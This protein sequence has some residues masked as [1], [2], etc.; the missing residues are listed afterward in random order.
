MCVY[1]Y[2]HTHTHT[3]GIDALLKPHCCAGWWLGLVLGGQGGEVTEAEL[4]F[5]TVFL[6]T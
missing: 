1:I 3:T 5:K 6:Y 4:A 2:I